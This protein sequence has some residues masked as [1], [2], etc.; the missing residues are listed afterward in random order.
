LHQFVFEG[1]AMTRRP[2]AAHDPGFDVFE[3]S[4]MN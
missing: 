2:G 1:D 4:P 3:N